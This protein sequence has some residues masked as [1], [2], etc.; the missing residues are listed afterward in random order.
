MAAPDH[1]VL[2]RPCFATDGTLA[3]PPDRSRVAVM[4]G[5][6]QAPPTPHDG[7][8]PW[9]QTRTRYPADIHAC[10]RKRVSGWRRRPSRRPFASAFTGDSVPAI[11]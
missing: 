3:T 1:T 6:T 10:R 9:A 11:R 2:I 5:L 4:A 7:I 8:A